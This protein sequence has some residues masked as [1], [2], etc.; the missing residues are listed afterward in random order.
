MHPDRKTAIFLGILLIA[1]ILFGILNS[2]PAIEAPDYLTKLSAIKTQ[3]LIAVFFQSAM[4]AVYVGIAVLFY[5][6]LKKY[7]ENFALGYFGFR[8]IGATF[9]F[10]GIG[11]LL[12]LLKLSQSYVSA[13]Q[14]NAPYFQTIGELLRTA[15]D[16]M[17]HIGMILPWSLGGLI[18]YYGTFKMKLIPKWLSIWGIIGSSLT[19]VATFMLML[20]VIRIVTPTYFIMNMPTALFELTLALVLIVKGFNPGVVNS[21]DHR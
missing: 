16:L 19:L 13:G 11:S 14:L 20:D 3:V 5:P 12:L 7:H 10:I 21:K 17:N 9:L 1:G 6:I 2:V 4:A 8:I 15:R 18:L